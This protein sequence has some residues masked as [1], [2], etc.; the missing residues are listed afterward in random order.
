M[1]F[2]RLYQGFS[3][4]NCHFLFNG[5]FYDQVNGVAM[6]SPLGPLLA[7]I[8]LSHHEK[9]WLDNCPSEFKPFFYR[10]YVDDSFILF[11]S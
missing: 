10:R 7:N 4:K 9:I 5:N 11:Q 6:G 3:L 1:V 2:S 8:F